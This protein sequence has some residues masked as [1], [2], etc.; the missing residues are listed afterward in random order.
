MALSG[1]E[2]IGLLIASG[3]APEDIAEI[4]RSSER[5]G[6]HELW[7]PEDYFFIGGVAGAAIALGA[8]ER[9]PVGIGVVASTVRHPAVT[10][11]EI[12][13]LARAFPNRIMPGIGHGIPAWIGQMGL[14]PRSP[15]AA[16][17]ESL[18]SIRALLGG[19]SVSVE[20]KAFTFRD[21]SLAHSAESH[22]PLYTGVL[23]DKGIALTG[24]LADGLLVSA[25]SPVEYVASARVKLDS[26]AAAAGREKR[27]GVSV[28]LLANLTDDDSKVP[29][30]RQEMR[31]LLAFYIAATGPC[32][33]F[34]AI[35]A[36]DQIGDMLSRG[37][38]E[39]V[40]AEMPE[41]WIDAFALVGSPADCRARMTQYFAA[42][43]DSVVVSPVPA[44]SAGRT[45]SV[46][47]QMLH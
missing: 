38:A 45:L 13:T 4:A 30:L 14:T 17:R 6:F 26:A 32:A 25:L 7:L 23:G 16:L 41:S 35:G 19:Q 9:I 18:T 22:V 43:A 36:N 2:R 21:V 8:T 5:M 47:E 11:M 44:G 12:A 28:L 39:V 15:M 20:G 46:L 31:E 24:E 27:L 34:G 33:L 40:A 10:A 3:T 37:G 29:A 1:G 42:G